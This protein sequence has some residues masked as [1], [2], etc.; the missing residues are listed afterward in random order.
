M[1]SD[2]MIANDKASQC[3]FS[4]TFVVCKQLNCDV[5]D[6]QFFFIETRQDR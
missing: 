6:M 3:E 2:E 5:T 4:L 1:H